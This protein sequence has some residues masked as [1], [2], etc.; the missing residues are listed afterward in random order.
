MSKA[1]A[2]DIPMPEPI[3]AWQCVGC[4]RLEAPQT[5][6]GV[7]QDR[8]VE[9]IGAW[10]YAEVRAA[11]D[12]ANE[13]IAALEAFLSRVA[14]IEPRTGRWAESY[15]ALQTQARKLLNAPENA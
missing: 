5:C 4:G 9:V 3:T 8:K 2:R 12:E 7:C 15:R 13:R 1:R 11:L 14:R 6:I 10:D